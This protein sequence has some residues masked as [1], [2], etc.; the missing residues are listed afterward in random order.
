M[1]DTMYNNDD[2]YQSLDEN[3]VM[4]DQ[5]LDKMKEITVQNEM[6]V[7]TLVA[8]QKKLDTIEQDIL[9]SA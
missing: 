5:I 3:S 1:S 2:I 6:L 9:L 4:T 8:M 7:A